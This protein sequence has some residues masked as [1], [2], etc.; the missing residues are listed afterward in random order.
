[1]QLDRWH[2]LLQCYLPVQPAALLPS[3]LAAAAVAALAAAAA[4]TRLLQA[5]LLPSQLTSLVGD[6]PAVVAL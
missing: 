6:V 1:L 5:A 3:L 4:Q 2:L